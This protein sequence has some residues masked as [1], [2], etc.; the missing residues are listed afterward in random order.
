MKSSALQ[1]IPIVIRA[2]LML[3]WGGVC[4]AL[5]AAPLLEAC[6]HS[7]AGGMFRAIFSL[8]CHQDPARSFTLLGH[9]W[10]VCH[11]CSGIYLGLFL[12]SLLPRQLNAV[13]HVPTH[14]RAWVMAATAPLLADVLLPLAGL[15]VNTTASRLVTGVIFGCML[16][17]LLAPALAELTHEAPWKHTGTGVHPQGGL[18]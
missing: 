2:S 16:T 7:F 17:S 15:W 1:T 18:E 12:L 8:I 5:I 9:P 3:L 11:R 4:A 10:A 6:G 13:V 14:R